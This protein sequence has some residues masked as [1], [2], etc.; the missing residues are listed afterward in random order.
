MARKT[1][2]GVGIEYELLG[3]AGAPAV[4]I[5]PGGRFPM[6]TPGVR[7]LGEKLAAGGKRVLLW[8][9]P[10][11]GYSDISFDAPSESELSSTTLTTLIRELDLG[12]TALAAGSAGSRVS[13]IAASR[14]PE[15]VSHMVL[16]WIS[17]G[18]IGLVSLANYY[19]ADSALAAS[20]GG[21]EAV[22]NLPGWAE[23]IRRNPKNR[24]IIMAQDPKAFIK[25]MESWAS[26][27]LP[28]ESSPVPGMT[29]AD[30][31]KLTMPVRL[32]QNGESDLS[33]TRE[34]SEWVHKLIPHSELLD[35][36]WADDE[37][38]H[39]SGTATPDGKPALFSGWPAM[40]PY[41][42][43]FIGR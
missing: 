36:P 16:W 34:T 27:Y 17:G 20:K 22:A 3:D 2:G 37:W 41:I 43:D 39:R 10:N 13:L 30:F 1:I 18:M 5:T 9:R 33:H 14:D 15:I 8:D 42:L 35:P 29:P 38:N 32:F 11:C 31:A 19:C 26:F 21:M 6:D 40:A 24:D 28:T 12:P 4:A 7:E 25:K 23:Q